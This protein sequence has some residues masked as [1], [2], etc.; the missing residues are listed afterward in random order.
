MTIYDSATTEELAALLI[1]EKDTYQTLSNLQR[2]TLEIAQRRVNELELQLQVAHKTIE[3]YDEGQE[4]MRKRFAECKNTYNSNDE[5]NR[6]NFEIELLKNEIVNLKETVKDCD[7]QNADLE[8][9]LQAAQETVRN[10]ETVVETCQASYQDLDTRY[11]ASEHAHADLIMKSETLKNTNKYLNNENQCLADKIKY[12][13]NQLEGF[14]PFR[15]RALPDRVSEIS[16]NEYPVTW[17]ET[18]D[19]AKYDPDSNAF[20]I[21]GVV[22]YRIG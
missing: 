20:I 22:T 3:S 9:E 18:F 13:E 17:V 8:I 1:T 7:N 10:L 19:P 11:T 12:L 16:N 4:I 2:M 6:F 14:S 15:W 5:V 21:N